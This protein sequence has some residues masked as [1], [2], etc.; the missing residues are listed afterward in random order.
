[1]KKRWF[2]GITALLL[3]LGIWVTAAETETAS[4]DNKQQ[5]EKQLPTRPIRLRERLQPRTRVSRSDPNA[6]IPRPFAREQMQP[7]TTPLAALETRHQEL[8]AELTSILK[9]A[10]EENASKTA[11]AVQKLIDKHNAEYKQNLELLQ[12]RRAEMQR[13]IEQRLRERRQQTNADSSTQT[14][15]AE[16][17]EDGSKEQP[18]KN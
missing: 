16:Q 2:L 8:I 1:M 11:E 7:G 10:Q 13:R 6:P 9:L 14:Q 5:V 15:S 12:Q 17:K 3:G 4:S 18:A